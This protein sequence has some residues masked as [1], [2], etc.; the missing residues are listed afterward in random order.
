M[1]RRTTGAMF[2]LIAAIL[3]SARYISAAIYMSNVSSWNR[4]M[5]EDALYYVGSHLSTLATIS[6]ILGA[7]YL[8]LAEIIE[9][10][11]K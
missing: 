7:A 3:Q 9:F 5:F 4:D 8:L 10:K 11:K 6:L 1:S 2:C